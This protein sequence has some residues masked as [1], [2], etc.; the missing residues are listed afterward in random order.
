MTPALQ[1]ILASRRCD[2]NTFHGHGCSTLHCHIVGFMCDA[3]AFFYT[4]NNL[5]GTNNQYSVGD[6]MEGPPIVC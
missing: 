6:I 2:G 5:V 3:G 1:A 4:Y